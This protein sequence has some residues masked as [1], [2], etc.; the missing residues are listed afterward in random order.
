MAKIH[1]FEVGYCTHPACIA[2]RGAGLAPR[3][4]PTRAYAIETKGGVYLWDTGYSEAFHAEAAG[5][6][7]IYT[8]VTP[9]HYDHAQDRL[10]AQLH[11][12]GVGVQDI[13]AVLISHFHADHIAGLREYPQVPLYA[14][15]SAIESIRGLVGLKA[16]FNG[17]IPGL[18][19]SDFGA[20]VRSF[21]AAAPLQLPA[22]LRPF[23]FGWPVDAFGEIWIVPLP[24]HA[25]GH[26]GAFVATESGWELLAG[27][28]AWAPEGYQAMVG[29]SDLSF[30]I[31]HNKKD[32]Y[33]TLSKLHQLYLSSTVRIHLSH[34][35]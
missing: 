20:R 27:D 18:L 28:A 4:F 2:L 32:Y 21:D 10:L 14:S 16:L 8:W 6:Y 13:Q 19:P 12:A 31:Q 29:P 22:E 11:A 15:L 17:F 1:A 9:V 23:R 26:V 33:E 3:K 25:V 34:E 5:V 24:G 30:L 35:L 7:R